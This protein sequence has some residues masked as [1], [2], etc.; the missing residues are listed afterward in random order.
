[1]YPQDE[2]NPSGREKATWIIEEF[3][4]DGTPYVKCSAC[5]A[6]MRTYVWPSDHVGKVVVTRIS[7]VN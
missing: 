6:H 5:D 1:M 7:M 3:L 4:R 2:A